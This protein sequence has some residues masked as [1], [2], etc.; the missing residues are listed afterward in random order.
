MR[1]FAGMSFYPGRVKVNYLFKSSFNPALRLLKAPASDGARVLRFPPL[2]VKWMFSMYHPNPEIFSENQ[3]GPP[4]LFF[5]PCAPPVCV[6]EIS[7]VAGMFGYAFLFL[8]SSRISFLRDLPSDDP[9]FAD[10][11]N[12]QVA[13]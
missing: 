4:P 8:G 9:P 3:E 1:P 10:V 11:H 2:V 12:S 13:W 7:T 5:G 6:R